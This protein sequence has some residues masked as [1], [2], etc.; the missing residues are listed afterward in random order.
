MAWIVSLVIYLMLRKAVFSSSSDQSGLTGWSLSK[1]LA[2]MFRDSIFI[3]C[4]SVGVTKENKGAH[5]KRRDSVCIEGKCRH[6]NTESS[7]QESGEAGN[8]LRGS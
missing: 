6:T 5:Q 7:F 8:L 2:N 4:K 3:K 1:I